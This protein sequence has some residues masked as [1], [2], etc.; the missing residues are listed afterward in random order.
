M[1]K[2]MQANTSSRLLDADFL[3]A[4]SIF[5]VVF[6]HSALI[7]PVSVIPITWIFLSLRFCVPIFIFLW[8]YF[9]E[10][11]F[12]K[13]DDKRSYLVKRFCGLL[14]PFLFW[15][16]IYFFIVAD[17]KKL[18]LI[19]FITTHWI[20]SGWSGQYYFIILFQLVAAFAILHTIARYLVG[21]RIFVILIS[22]LFYTLISYSPLFNLG[23]IGK[24]N[25]RP[26]F[27][28]IPYVLLGISYSKLGIPKYYSF[29]IYFIVLALV[30]IPLEVFVFH[31]VVASHTPYLLPS[32]FIST[33]IILH[34]VLGKEMNYLRLNGFIFYLMDLLS[35][36]TLGIFCLNPLIVIVISYA[37]RFM[38]YKFDF[39]GHNIITP[40]VSTIFVIGICILII[41]LLKHIKLGVLITN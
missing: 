4:I 8:A 23:V 39:I 25:D 10:K 6:I 9:T 22:V 24:I 33:V 35:R 3:K 41:N 28:W 14:T 1:Y 38:N 37:L 26:F 30:L 7:I 17:F 13:A 2:V 12:E 40:I 18:T 21:K 20:G 32:A 29:P 15:S 11:S 36:N 5:A 19:K 27:Y 31:P 34:S 16:L